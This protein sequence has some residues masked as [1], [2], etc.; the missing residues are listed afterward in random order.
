MPV[1]SCKKKK[2]KNLGLG[3]FMAFGKKNLQ[4]SKLITWEI[5]KIQVGGQPQITNVHS[6]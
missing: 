2:K 4:Q 6:H 1:P 3:L 5:P